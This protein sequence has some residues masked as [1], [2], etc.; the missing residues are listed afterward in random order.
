MDLKKEAWDRDSFLND[1]FLPIII[2]FVCIVIGTTGV[3]KSFG[4]ISS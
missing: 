3:W 4:V 1:L 2:G